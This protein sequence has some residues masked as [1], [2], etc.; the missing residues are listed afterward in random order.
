MIGL[1]NNN[2]LNSKEEHVRVYILNPARVAQV[3]EYSVF[4]AV[5]RR[6]AGHVTEY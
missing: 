3:R 4:L 5:W 6:G 1:N 2:Y